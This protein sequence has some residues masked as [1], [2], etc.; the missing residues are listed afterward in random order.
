MCNRREARK[1]RQINVCG[2]EISIRAI[3]D[4]KKGKSLA[5]LRCNYHFE[6]CRTMMMDEGPEHVSSVSH[7][8]RERQW[9]RFF[10]LEK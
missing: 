7:D 9:C 3:D 2:T 4:L 8:Q 10:A 5:M 1:D 6:E